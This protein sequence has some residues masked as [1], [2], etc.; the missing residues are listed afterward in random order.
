MKKENIFKK[1]GKVLFSIG[2]GGL[3]ACYLIRLCEIKLL[4]LSEP[5]KR[6]VISGNMEDM[7]NSMLE[8]IILLISTYALFVAPLFIHW[9]KS[10]GK[11]VLVLL[12]VFFIDLSGSVIALASGEISLLYITVIWLSSI[13]VTWFCVGIAGIIYSW[14]QVGTK[15]TQLDM[16]KLTFIWTIIAFVLGKVW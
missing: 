8:V 11:R 5:I 1:L 3:I 15:D 2:V 4:P 14:L 16:V 9:N 10:F 13:Y 12:F 6:M 7:R